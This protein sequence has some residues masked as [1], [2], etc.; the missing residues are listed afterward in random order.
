MYDTVKTGYETGEVFHLVWEGLPHNLAYFEMLR[1]PLQDIKARRPLALHLV[2]A[3]HYHPYLSKFGHRRAEDLIR[4]VFDPVHLHEWNEATAGE[5]MTRCDLA[6]IPVALDKAF[7]AGKPE[8]K[9]LIFWKMGLP[10]V[11]SATPAYQ[12]TMEACGLDMACRSEDD[13]KKVLEKYVM[14]D[15]A[16]E[17]AA[18]KGRAY[19][20]AH[21]NE[22]QVLGRWDR[23]FESLF[24][25]RGAS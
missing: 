6:V 10:A 23:L 2:T 8:N 20:E 4:D 19:V 13:W 21:H 14:D 25:D 1:R 3:L 16:R 7:A 22:S 17:E 18:R 11:V 5:V 24:S 15:A 9:L 12:R